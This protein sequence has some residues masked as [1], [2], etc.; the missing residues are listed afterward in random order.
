MIRWSAKTHLENIGPYLQNID[1]IDES[2]D[3]REHVGEASS[4]VDKE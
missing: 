2:S 1:R 4:M 3:Q